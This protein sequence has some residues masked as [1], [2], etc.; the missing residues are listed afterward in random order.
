MTSKTRAVWKSENQFGYNIAG[1][2]EIFMV[3]TQRIF[4]GIN[5]WNNF[6]NRS[7]F[8][9]VINKHQVAYFFETQCKC[10][11]KYRNDII[12]THSHTVQVSF[13]DRA[14]KWR[15]SA[16]TYR[17]VY[18]VHRLKCLSVSDSIVVAETWRR[19]SLGSLWIPTT[20]S[21]PTISQ[22]IHSFNTLSIQTDTY[23]TPISGWQTDIGIVEFNVPL[24]TL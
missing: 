20:A 8:A 21:K 11:Y 14:I 10:M 12:L 7:T 4:L 9:K 17:R 19:S 2:V 18:L 23:G 6:E 22:I 5:W 15:R 3:H 16:H 1:E 13:E 24:D